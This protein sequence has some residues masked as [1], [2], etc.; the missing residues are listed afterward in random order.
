MCPNIW[1][2]FFCQIFLSKQGLQLLI[3]STL[4]TR[5]DANLTQLSN[6]PPCRRVWHERVRRARAR[7]RNAHSARAYVRDRS[8]WLPTIQSIKQ[9]YASTHAKPADHHA[10]VAGEPSSTARSKRSDEQTTRTF[11]P[12]YRSILFLY[13][14]DLDRWHCAEY[15]CRTEGSGWW[16]SF[17][18]SNPWCMCVERGCSI[19]VVVV[20]GVHRVYG[21]HW[22]SL[23]CS[24]HRFPIAE[25]IINWNTVRTPTVSFNGRKTPYR[26]SRAIYVLLSSGLA[27]CQNC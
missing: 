20:D 12:T 5:G 18:G 11:R 26:H 25:D 23:R 4:L 7:G 24:L 27:E 8:S 9:S 10:C 14:M 15:H 16:C 19:V 22:L 17:T 2:D 21:D 6:R 13:R 3:W 1:C